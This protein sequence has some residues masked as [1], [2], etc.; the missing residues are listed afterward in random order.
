MRAIHSTRLAASLLVLAAA[1]CAD[2][3]RATGPSNA[4]YGVGATGSLTLRLS[5]DAARLQSGQSLRVT[6]LVTNSSG[7]TVTVALTWTSTNTASLAVLRDGNVPGRYLM[8]MHPGTALLVVTGS[9]IA[10]TVRVA[11]RSRELPFVQVSAGDNNTCALD[12]AGKAWCWGRN[13]NATAPIQEVIPVPT[14]IVGGLAY[15]KV[16]GVG[17]YPGGELMCGLRRADVYCWGRGERLGGTMPVQRTQ[18]VDFVSLDVGRFYFCAVSVNAEGWCEGYNKL[19]VLGSR[20][21]FTPARVRGGHRWRMIDANWEHTCGI[22]TDYDLYCWG[23]DR[24][25]ALGTTAPVEKCIDGSGDETPCSYTPVLVEGGRKYRDVWGT[26]ALDLAGDV[27]CWPGPDQV[28][29]QRISGYGFVELTERCALDAAGRA[30]CWRGTSVPTL[31]PGLTF[32]SLSASESHVCGVATNGRVYCW[33]SN[34]YGQLGDGTRTDSAL[35]VRVLG[36][37]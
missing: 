31:V 35:P 15:T 3:T 12:S 29:T 14:P 10:D 1:S 7:D 36:Q 13:L 9:G 24:Y 30:W 23:S 34:T 33:G 8:G 11:V 27:W 26:C 25:G 32:T 20:T 28:P 5:V 17:S 2:S 16:S 21:V 18:G 6:A 22:T 4:Q 37:R 19:G